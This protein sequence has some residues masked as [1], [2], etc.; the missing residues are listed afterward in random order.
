MLRENS[1]NS[2]GIFNIHILKPHTLAIKHAGD[3]VVGNNEQLGWICEGFVFCKPAGLSVAMRAYNR[4]VTYAA[5]KP[6]CNGAGA[7]IG[8]QKSVFVKER[9]R[10]RCRRDASAIRIFVND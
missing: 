4:R 3:I 8:R 10:L 5:V 7:R 9:D 2:S 6:P 1:P